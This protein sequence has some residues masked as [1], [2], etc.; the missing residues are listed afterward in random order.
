MDV[1]IFASALTRLWPYGNSR[2]S[3]LIEGTIATRLPRS[4]NTAPSLLVIAHAMA[5]FSEESNAG[6]EMVEDMNYSAARLLKVFPGSI[7][8]LAR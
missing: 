3:G 5:E 7:A 4:P 6:L 8:P 1:A 2:I